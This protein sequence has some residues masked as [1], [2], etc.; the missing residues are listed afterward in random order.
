MKSLPYIFSFPP[1][2]CIP[3]KKLKHFYRIQLKIQGPLILKQYLDMFFGVDMPKNHF[4]TPIFCQEKKLVIHKTVYVVLFFRETK[5]ENHLLLHNCNCNFQAILAQLEF[6][7]KKM[8]INENTYSR[9]IIPTESHKRNG[10][11]HFLNES[12]YIDEKI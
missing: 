2:Y 12:L 5:I 11:K 1:N 8:K 4:K 6:S 10:V 9:N 3:E 7:F